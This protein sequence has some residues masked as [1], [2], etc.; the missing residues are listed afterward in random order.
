METNPETADGKLCIIKLAIWTNGERKEERVALMTLFESLL[1]EL[2]STDN[3]LVEGD[4]I[5]RVSRSEFTAASIRRFVHFDEEN[6][7]GVEN[8]L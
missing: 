2:M 8:G 7:I 1:S 5:L 4:T 6:V 3:A